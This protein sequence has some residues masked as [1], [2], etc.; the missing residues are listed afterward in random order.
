GAAG[1]A[2]A[3]S[4]GAAA[5]AG[6]G[7]GSPPPKASELSRAA[8][9]GTAHGSTARSSVEGMPHEQRLAREQAAALRSGAADVRL[10]VL[11]DSASSPAAGGPYA[12]TNA[13]SAQ[14]TSSASG[15]SWVGQLMKWMGVDHERLLATSTIRST[16]ASPMSATSSQVHPLA[17]EARHGSADAASLAAR[18]AIQERLTTSIGPVHGF[19]VPQRFAP[20]L[21]APPAGMPLPDLTGSAAGDSGKLG[22]SES[23]KSAL[24]TLAA[25]NDVSPSI[26]DAAQQLV[27]HITGQQLLMTPETNGALFSHVTLFVPMK[28]PDGSQTASVHIQTRRGRK[29]ELDGDNC[30]L[31]FDLRMHTLGD[32]VVDVQVVDR[33]VNL[34][35]WNDHPS[36]AGLLESTRG[37]LDDAL[38]KAGYALLTLR[39]E[40]MPERIAERMNGQD[41]TKATADSLEWSAKPYKGVDMRA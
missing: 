24:M 35:L 6:A 16:P 19:S 29:G 12:G 2:A 1:G 37:E 13:N 32:T 5:E 41:G 18:A 11:S 36:A 27:A 30:R 4:G 28:G 23:L 38:A 7:A 15:S 31:L 40:P 14:S 33:I 8:D 26:R 34:Q 21:A 10:G 39:A 17:G 20:L 22:S 25:A 3:R 9:A